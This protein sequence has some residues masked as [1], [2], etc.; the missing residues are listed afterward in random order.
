MGHLTVRHKKGASRL[1]VHTPKKKMYL[2]KF[3]KL[4]E[5]LT[6]AGFDGTQH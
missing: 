2:S 5:N 1:R 4:H 6:F 3:R